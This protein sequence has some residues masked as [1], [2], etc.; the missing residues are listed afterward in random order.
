MIEVRLYRGQPFV[1]RAGTDREERF[2][3][4][5]AIVV[6]DGIENPDFQHTSINEDVAVSNALMDF[7]RHV[8]VASRVDLRE[9][10]S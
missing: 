3:T 1:H 4:T 10:R 2:E 8:G 6:E 7:A 5:R 9:V